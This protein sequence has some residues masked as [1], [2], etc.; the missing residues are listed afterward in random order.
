MI[1]SDY[2]PSAML[3]IFGL[4]S[5]SLSLFVKGCIQNSPV[6]YI[7]DPADSGMHCQHFQKI[8]FDSLDECDCKICK[9]YTCM[10][11]AK[12]LEQWR[13]YIYS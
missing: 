6:T 10:I 1:Q 3:M 8:G 2:Q 7:V 9:M 5:L 13:F 4:A 12:T 11:I